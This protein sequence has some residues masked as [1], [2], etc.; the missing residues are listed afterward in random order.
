M[1]LLVLVAC[2]VLC[3]CA[4]KHALGTPIPAHCMT[5]QIKDFTKP[6]QTLKDGDLM[7]NGVRVHV[8][9]VAVR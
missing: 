1:K 3:G 6:C 4:A 8:E 2:L 7:C 5:V 9:C